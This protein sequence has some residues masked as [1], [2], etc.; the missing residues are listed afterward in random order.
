MNS[1]A[2]RKSIDE[3]ES[4]IKSMPQVVIPVKHTFGKNIYMREI[5]I[6]K[7]LLLTGKVHKFES[8]HIIQYGKML[9]TTEEGKRVI[10]G[11]CTQYSMP[12]VKRAGYALEDTYWIT[13]HAID[14]VNTMKEEDMA[15]YLT[16]NTY[17]EYLLEMSSYGLIEEN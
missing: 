2:L 9:V 5:L 3:L 14:N 12:G 1:L 10:E 13:V 17:E 6:P 16:T 11:P 4:T 8:M 7:G 15:D